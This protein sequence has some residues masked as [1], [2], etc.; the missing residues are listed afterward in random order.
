MILWIMLKISQWNC[1]YLHLFRQ[2]PGASNVPVYC[3]WV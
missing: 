2:S 3:E 1:T